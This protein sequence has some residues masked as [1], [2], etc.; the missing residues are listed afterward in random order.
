MKI[1]SAKQ[2]KELDKLT[3]H[4]QNITPL[5]L[6]ERAAVKCVTFLDN[7]VKAL[8]Y[9]VFAGMGDNGGDGFA[10]ARLM[11]MAGTDVSVVV[12]KHRTAFSAS[13]ENN[14]NRIVA[15][16]VPVLMVDQ[17]TS[18]HKVFESVTSRSVIIDAVFGIGFNG[19]LPHWIESVFKTLS[20][21]NLCAKMVVSI[22]VPSGLRF[23]PD[24][25]EHNTAVV[26]CEILLTFQSP[27]LMLFFPEYAYAF[28][29]MV[30]LDIGLEIDTYQLSVHVIDGLEEFCHF[31]QL[32]PLKIRSRTAHKGSCGHA[33]VIGGSSGKIGAAVL[34]TR[35]TIASGAGLVTSYI[36]QCGG[37]IMT[38]SIPDA[39][40]ICDVG[41]H[42]I[43]NL[44]ID[45]TPYSVVAIG[46]GLGTSL[47]TEKALVMLLRACSTQKKT[48]VIDADGLNILASNS[49]LIRLLPPGTILTPHLK[50]LERLIGVSTSESHLTRL[51]L[52]REFCIKHQ[53]NV[54]V[55]GCFS[56]VVTQ[57]GLL[58]FN[59]SGNQG[60]ATAGSGDVL[61]GVLAGLL[62]S[63]PL[64][65]VEV[66]IWGCYVHGLAADIMVDKIGYESVTASGVIENLGYAFKQSQGLR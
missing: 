1:F 36:P 32:P 59:A 20:S 39:M 23:T 11:Y 21:N 37:Q 42:A 66:A 46:P 14:Y 6:M 40:V 7:E 22:D 5:D 25:S 57:E 53:L 60:L 64:S 48:M 50:E 49:D 54:I 4:V 55:K 47:A 38:I 2:I 10:I 15:I 63:H 30:V 65:P 56:V 8:H 61:T 13:A 58:Y 31:N 45:I 51:A 3:C 9:V 35:A 18:L 17:H 43:T 33:L 24:F 62:A 41:G 26:E 44:D 34:T 19:L 29:K 28:Q 16:G 12:I 27:K 52:T